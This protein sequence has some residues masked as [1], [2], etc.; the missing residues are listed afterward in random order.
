MLIADN[1]L[2]ELQNDTLE[3]KNDND[4][5]D[6]GTVLNFYSSNATEPRLR[7]SDGQERAFSFDD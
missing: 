6:F 1:L 4:D 7:C 3:Y 5:I 2:K